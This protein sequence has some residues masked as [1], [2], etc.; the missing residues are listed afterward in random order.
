M[1]KLWISIILSLIVLVTL[2][3]AARALKS[4]DK[5]P[6][7]KLM[8]EDMKYVTLQEELKKGPVLLVFYLFDFTEACHRQ[9]EDFEKIQKDY[10]QMKLQV[11]GVR[12][13]SP[14][15]HKA[16]RGENKIQFKLL[17]D[18]NKEASQRYGAYFPDLMGLKGV[19][20]RA[21]FLIGQDGKIKYAQVSDKP[22]QLPDVDKARQALNS[23]GGNKPVLKKKK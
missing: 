1:R 11:Y 12:V 9:M 14:F 17:S 3:A 21:V 6:G 5:A 23:L 20:K 13:E 15:A 10:S 18:F 4:G 8:D 19:S 7:F 2:G 16:W 22:Q